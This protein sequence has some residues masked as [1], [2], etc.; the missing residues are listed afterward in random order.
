MNK[1][2]A[3]Q[4]YLNPLEKAYAIAST[5]NLF[6]ENTWKTELNAGRGN[7]YASALIAA[8]KSGLD[9]ETLYKKY[10]L[11]TGDKSTFAAALYNELL[12]DELGNRNN[13]K[14]KY[15]FV[16]EAGQ[17][18]EEELTEYE[19]NLK[20]IQ[21]HNIQYK[22]KVLEDRM[23]ELNNP[24][25]FTK[26]LGTVS[27]IPSE[28]GTGLMNWMNDLGGFIYAIGKAKPFLIAE[29]KIGNEAFGK[30]MEE[31]QANQSDTW[32]KLFGES[33]DG[34]DAL[35]WAEKEL[36]DFESKYT[37]VRDEDGNITSFGQ[38][39]VGAMNTIAAM[40]PSMMT[41]FA[42]APSAIAQS[43]FYGGFLAGDISEQ[44]NARTVEGLDISTDAIIANAFIKTALQYTVEW[45]LG[46]A[47]GVSALDRLIYGKTGGKLA[48]S[49]TT[50]ALKDLGFSAL[51]EGTEEVLQEFT[52][53]MTNKAFEWLITKEYAY[54]SKEIS[55]KTFTDAFFLGAVMSVLGGSVQV[56]LTSKKTSF[57]GD[58]TDIKTKKLS[59]LASYGYNINLQSFVETMETLQ[60]DN[61]T[62]KNAKQ[63]VKNYAEAVKTYEVL[64]GIYTYMGEERFAQANE[65]L[66][67]VREA[68]ESGKF[69]DINYAEQLKKSFSDLGVKHSETIFK[70]AESHKFGEA[71]RN[72]ET[73]DYDADE[74]TAEIFKEAVE[75]LKSTGV[76]NI[77]ETDGGNG[78]VISEDG[79]TIV[80]PS[81][82]INGVGYDVANEMLKSAASN[83]MVT[84][85][86]NLVPDEI[87]SILS[88]YFSEEQYK[89]LSREDIVTLLLFNSD[90]YTATLLSGNKDVYKFLSH[91][92]NMA[93]N[94][95]PKNLK[96][97]IF[98]E[99]ISKVITN[100]VNALTQ[101]SQIHLEVDYTEWTSLLTKD[102]RNKVE[103][104]IINER[105]AGKLY[106]RVVLNQLTDSEKVL[107]KS[108]IE[109]LAIN[110]SVKTKLEKQLFDSNPTVRE[111]GVQRLLSYY[112]S[113][114]YK[115]YDGKVYLPDN[116]IA[117]RVFNNYL[118]RNGFT[119]ETWLSQ[120]NLTQE[121]VLTVN[122]M[123]GS[124]GDFLRFRNEQ[125]KEFTGY[126]F[127]V[128]HGKV[129]VFKNDKAVG[130]SNYARFYAD[131][132]TPP[133][134][135]KIGTRYEKRNSKLRGL[136]NSDVP[137]SVAYG[138]SI[139][140]VILNHNLL[141]GKVHEEIVKFAKEQYDVELD[142]PSMEFTYLYL[143][144]HFLETENKAIVLSGDGEFVFVDLT[145]IENLFKTDVITDRMSIEDIINEKYIPAGITIRFVSDVPY[146]GAFTSVG[147]ANVPGTPSVVINQNVIY[148]NKAILVRQRTAKFVIA[149]EL[150]HAIQYLNGMDSGIT[151][152]W[153]TFVS[154]SKFDEITK[155]I[156]THVPELFKSD[157]TK[158]DIARTVIDFVYYGGQGEISANGLDGSTGYKFVP[159]VV[160]DN[161]TVT[162]PW[163]YSFT[164]SMDKD[165]ENSQ[166]NKLL[167]EA[168]GSPLF[169]KFFK[170]V[171]SKIDP[172]TQLSESVIV[173]SKEVCDYAAGS[174]IGDDKYTDLIKY[175]GMGRNRMLA[176]SYMYSLYGQN[177]TVEE[178]LNSSIPAIVKDEISSDGKWALAHVGTSIETMLSNLNVV[179][180]NVQGNN[181]IKVINVPV[182]QIIGYVDL[183]SRILVKAENLKTVSQALSQPAVLADTVIPSF[184]TAP[185]RKSTKVDEDEGYRTKKHKY[186][187]RIKVNGKYKYIYPKDERVNVTKSG[188]EGT[189]LEMFYKVAED[190]GV[191]KKITPE[192]KAL[193]MK[194]DKVELDEKIQRKID[195]GTLTDDDVL[196]F[197]T[198]EE[199]ISDETFSTI[200]SI[201][202][203][204]NPIKTQKELN[205]YMYEYQPKYYGLG[206]IL[207]Q[208]DNKYQTNFYSSVFDASKLDSLIETVKTLDEA[209]YRDIL[210]IVA[211]YNYIHG[212]QLR[213][214]EQYNIRRWLQDFD[215]TIESGYE[216][217]A[218]SRELAD[219]IRKG[220][221]TISQGKSLSLDAKI[222]S[223][224][225]TYGEAVADALGNAQKMTYNELHTAVMLIYMELNADRVK[226]GELT[227]TALQR[228]FKETTEG[229]PREELWDFFEE[230]NEDAPASLVTKSIMTVNGES[231][232]IDRELIEQVTNEEEI[233]KIIKKKYSLVQKTKNKLITLRGR[234]YRTLYKDIYADNGDILKKDLTLNESYYK[235]ANGKIDY[236]KLQD[237]F[238]RIT[239]LTEK[240]K[241]GD[242]RSRVD[243]ELSEKRKKD[244]VNAIK[245]MQ[246][247]KLSKE[248]VTEGDGVKVIKVQERGDVLTPVKNLPPIVEKI[249]TSE[250]HRTHKTEVQR[251]TLDNE[252]H[253]VRRMKDFIDNNVDILNAM[254]QSD[255]D[256]VVDFYLHSSPVLSGTEKAR[257]ESSR[258]FLL[259]YIYLASEQGTNSF[260]LSND[261]VKDIE[262]FIKDEV[263]NA[264]TIGA[265]WRTVLSY[266]NKVDPT[267]EM[268]NAM[269]RKS[270]IPEDEILDELSGLLM[271]QIRENKIE[272]AQETQAKLYARVLELRN[273][274][275]EKYEENKA[276]RDKIES[277]IKTIKKS[278]KES[279]DSTSR[280]KMQNK[281]SE[282]E[283]EKLKYSDV[284]IHPKS[285]LRRIRSLQATFMLSGPGTILRS[286]I[287]NIQV[288]YTSALADVVGNIHRI[289]GID[290]REKRGKDGT[291]HSVKYFKNKGGTYD[292]QYRLFGTAPS[293]EIQEFVKSHLV[294]NDLLSLI[295][296]SGTRYEP[297]RLRHKTSDNIIADMITDKLNYQYSLVEPKTAK[298]V[299]KFYAKHGN[300][301]KVA[302]F[303]SDSITR[304]GFIRKLLADDKWINE[305]TIWYAERMI[306]ED[307]EN[308]KLDKGLGDPKVLEIIASAYT[309][310][311][312]D[313]MHR[314]NF[315][316]KLESTLYKSLGE[317]GM[318]LYKQIF[319]FMST[320]WNWFLESLNYSPVGLAK[321]IFKIAKLETTVAKAEYEF[322]QGKTAENPRFAEYIAHQEL[323]KGIIGSFGT[324][325]GILLVGFGIVKFVEDDDERK[326]VIGDISVDV[327]DL[328]AS[329][330][331]ILGMSLV[332]GIKDQ[333]TFEKVLGDTAEILLHDSALETVINTFRYSN[334]ISDFMSSYT[335]NVLN[336]SVPN[337][338]KTFARVT[339]KYEIKYSSGLQGGIER[340]AASIP[341]ADRF[342][343]SKVDVYTGEKQ[344]IYNLA[345]LFS[346]LLPVDVE[347]MN[348]SSNELIAISHGVTK[349][350][351]SGNYREID[352]KASDVTKLNQF[353]G[354]LNKK[355]LSNFYNNRVKERVQNDDGSYSELYYSQMTEKQKGAATK[356]IMSG[357]SA[358]AKIYVLT[359]S[360]NFKYYASDEEYRELRK[361]GITKNI[362]HE[363]NKLKGFVK[364]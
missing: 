5:T 60:N 210:N 274:T 33:P 224:G 252:R 337:F 146:E 245:A 293:K 149:H 221:A 345:E 242:Y 37:Y 240:A 237:A 323:G 179:E 106:N 239:E 184:N 262:N 153:N 282:L 134:N 289:G 131:S 40:I 130:F 297:E 79:E 351:L 187:D 207:K 321:A 255:V 256:Q 312:M 98:K 155:Q 182:K 350:E 275:E 38:Y 190:R 160:R 71:V 28:I 346:A 21:L 212:E 30:A 150:Q 162:F 86:T 140:D 273:E 125:L 299:A 280:K 317:P 112:S 143:R 176:I 138:L 81:N 195:N 41:G 25:W 20:S 13:A 287:S 357:N 6:D 215:G 324:L 279:S 347:P 108:R 1:L 303:L 222:G 204:N 152:D 219:F 84:E 319:P 32:T 135:I 36:A 45:G 67:K 186:I 226:S 218:K 7:E 175:F 59:K 70:Q 169:N 340:M 88:G 225:R 163:G 327:N 120:D 159:I 359:S 4:R 246:S 334:S 234:V 111:K 180:V 358:Y 121:E 202:Y 286:K 277:E 343:A 220:K 91:F 18:Y 268:H 22:N 118:K 341:F 257:F 64:T 251:F 78:A 333:K 198:T 271:L 164:L 313:Y 335:F 295:A 185:K 57:V 50:T 158:N 290:T 217:G 244:F 14:N 206:A 145:S 137:R 80:A 296:D 355:S 15:T 126:E 356:T 197:M 192:L 258:L 230:L 68:Q 87:Y 139:D 292:D 362:Y 254:T 283:I 147:E 117:N 39:Y 364:T 53:L 200:M 249:F 248:V 55:L 16:N 104:K 66:T 19:Y 314:P 49:F 8:D 95:V 89:N 11:A 165:N 75:K 263:S 189:P 82:M 233:K 77:V 51:Q 124:E 349:T 173:N 228:E 127:K 99:S 352:L 90:V 278:I 72:I 52:D 194:S 129:T 157:A 83:Y 318:F 128:S 229:M 63:Y 17:E 223:T 105:I 148:I 260:T 156:K 360:G 284:S 144:S 236:N 316:G 269:R 338:I 154:K 167:K 300:N 34:T 109:A 203:P 276:E 266:L 177:L 302:G 69:D 56:G 168:E 196:T 96:D 363:T 253:Y 304:G 332:N 73:A 110:Q 92:I 94:V 23:K 201:F 181:D 320:S 31:H 107:L 151:N 205:K 46:K 331:I 58:S 227:Y 101:Y 44:I 61:M 54:A 354:E 183:N 272:D 329:Q 26:V 119:V 291:Y 315:I 178:F 24:N 259:S 12:Y 65:L 310:A 103:S 122:E 325:V 247:P 102:I 191:R 113:M 270:G 216:I 342:L 231:L 85:L 136:L 100:W 348:M 42:G 330:G 62:A 170:R 193:I 166:R 213:F 97:A 306:Q 305:R 172:K 141:S 133:A 336:T 294:D 238:N 132:E 171:N 3:M 353:Y 209:R 232:H 285:L 114:Y 281:L 243:Y 174:L 241:R 10:N 161:T 76:K 339:R 93:K 74:E 2:R 35:T 328:Y 265:S 199:D 188:S 235:D 43:V 326:I 47:F 311:A 298:A 267:K 308:L 309:R 123:G 29:P 344:M 250:L 116:S 301:A 322:S 9:A 361:L 214:D 261:I 48:S 288:K 115:N 211:R 142:E 27:T 264:M 307:A 208:I